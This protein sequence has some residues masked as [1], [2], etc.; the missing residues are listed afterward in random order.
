QLAREA[1]ARAE[2]GA[3][4]VARLYEHA[5]RDGGASDRVDDLKAALRADPAAL[6][7]DP[8]AP[9][10]PLLHVAAALGQTDLAEL[11]LGTGADP[12]AKDDQGLT[13]LDYAAMSLYDDRPEFIEAVL[14]GGIE[15]GVYAAAATGRVDALRNLLDRDR[16]MASGGPGVRGA[17][18][19]H[20]A[21]W[22]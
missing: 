20:V 17:S 11:L 7:A 12:T 10:C 16:S 14:A 4:F 6:S 22:H 3:G 13:P 21:A 1:D 9:G 19:L 5:L 2:E 18:P 8:A 15:P